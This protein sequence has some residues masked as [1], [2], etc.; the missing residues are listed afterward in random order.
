MPRKSE[1]ATVDEGSIFPPAKEK[2]DALKRIRAKDSFFYW[3][4]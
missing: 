3:R 1:F 4:A 2:N